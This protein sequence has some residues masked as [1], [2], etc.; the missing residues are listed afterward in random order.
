MASSTLHTPPRRY[1]TVAVAPAAGGYAVRLDDRPL[2]TPA[3]RAMVL[4][5]AAL[6]EA[7]AA[8]WRGQAGGRPNIDT[9]PLTRVAATAIDRIPSR[10]AGVIDELAAYAETELVCHRAGHPPALVARQQ[11]LWQ[12]LLDWLTYRFDAALAVTTGVL[13]HAQSPTSLAAL[14]RAI[15]A[16]DDFR[17]AGLSVAVSAAGSLV[18]GLALAE[19]RLDA[20][21]AFD[22]AELDASFQIEQWGED[23]LAARRRAAVRGDLEAAERF[24]KLVAG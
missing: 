8:E 19:G 24:L 16:L 4:P 21:G 10:R 11:A 12:P 20:A 2:R 23:S 15:E 9:L 7:V 5:S 14:R 6:A 13:P 3:G 17:L 22:A 1:K 18:I